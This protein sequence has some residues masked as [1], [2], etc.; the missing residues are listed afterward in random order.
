MSN[1]NSPSRE[2]TQTPAPAASKWGLGRE[3]QAAVLRVRIGSECPEGNLRELTWASKPDCGIATM[4]KALVTLGAFG[5]ILKKQCSPRLPAQP[6]L[7]S[8]GCRRLHCFFT[9]GGGGDVTVG[10]VICGF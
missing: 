5:L 1:G 10:L 3:A 8:G 7:A 9:G 4:R 2:V 6:P